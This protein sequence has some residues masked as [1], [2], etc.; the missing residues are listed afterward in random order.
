MKK[1]ICFSFFILFGYAS[2]AQSDSTEQHGFRKENLFTG[3]NINLGFGTGSF[4]IGV[5][6]MFGYSVTKW[7]DA[8]IAINYAHFTQK[9]YPV[10]NKY[11]QN[12]YGGGPFLRIFPVRF[13]FAQAQFEH[14]FIDQKI[15]YA[16]G[17]PTDALH[18]ESNSFLVGAGYTSGR[19]TGSDR[20]AYG[21][22]S[23]LFDVMND[24]NS[25]YKDNTNSKQPVIRGGIIVP[26]FQGKRR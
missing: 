6:P 21:Y 10:A 18:V 11:I 12:V 5:G 20:S 8:G 16:N 15:K 2:F 1:L 13:L 4:S 25:P 19:L 24:A 17:N 22:L 7:L 23:I 14:N 9:D 26:L 3:G